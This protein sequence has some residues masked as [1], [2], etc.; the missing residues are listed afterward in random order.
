MNA[1]REKPGKPIRH[2]SAM[3]LLTTLLSG[4]GG[5]GGSSSSAIDS[6]SSIQPDL[7]PTGQDGGSAT[8]TWV[9]P[10]TREDGSAFSLSQLGGYKIYVGT[11][12]GNLVPAGT[13]DDP[14]VTSYTVRNIQQGE[15][16]FAVTA[17][18][19]AGIESGFSNMVRKAVN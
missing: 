8:L 12:D 11:V 14:T 9:A 3:L 17:F 19:S 13:I 18:D 4:C 7:S 1:N 6:S 15:Y 16:I 2:A 5:G 10:S